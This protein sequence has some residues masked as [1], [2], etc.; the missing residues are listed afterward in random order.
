MKPS[1]LLKILALASIAGATGLPSLR[2]ADPVVLYR[3]T[4]GNASE[5]NSFLAELGI[6]WNVY[7]GP[8]AMEWT[9]LGAVVSSSDSSPGNLDN[10]GTAPSASPSH[11]FIYTDNQNEPFLLYTQ[12]L[13]L[14][15]IKTPKLSFAWHAKNNRPNALQRAALQVNGSW[16]V[17]ATTFSTSTPA[18]TD[19]SLALVPTVK[20]HRLDF[21][22]RAK[23]PDSIPPSATAINLPAG[24]IT[25]FG[26]YLEKSDDYQRFDT[27]TVLIP[28][29]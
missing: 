28:S 5:Q 23:L 16:Y 27:F 4:F 29:R 22:P 7:R 9:V 18:W 21:S 2:A 12:T 11:G 17:S 24:K 15:P 13:V 10:V 3:Q 25:G 1:S 26:L 6:P 14:D 19:Q 20:W 8:Q